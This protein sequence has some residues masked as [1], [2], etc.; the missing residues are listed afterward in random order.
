MNEVRTTQLTAPL[1]TS[2]ALS[3]GIETAKDVASKE[4]KPVSEEI[5]KKPQTEEVAEAAVEDAVTELNSYVQSIQRDL[6]F[7]I[8]EDSG[9]TVV[10][11]RDK[12]SGELIR[13]IPEDIFLNL[14]QKLKDDNT[15]SLLDAYG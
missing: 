11:V 9:V 2:A 5:E 14:A 6:H 10:R 13:Q 8:D 4:V 12:E 7:S 3:R 15:I 1:V